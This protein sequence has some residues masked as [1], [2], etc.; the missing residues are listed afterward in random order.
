MST[1]QT[2]GTDFY[3]RLDYEGYKE[4]EEQLKNYTSLETVHVSVEGFY[5]KAFR[6][7]VGSTV[8]EFM[9]PTVPKPVG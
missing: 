3:V 5:H 1:K 6:L 2:L 4:L 9:G 8:F 7:K